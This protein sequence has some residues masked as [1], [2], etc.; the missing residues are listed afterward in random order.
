M[1][2][3]RRRKTAPATAAG[4]ASRYGAWQVTRHEGGAVGLSLV[5]GA[6]RGAA[7]RQMGALVFAIAN[8]AAPVPGGRR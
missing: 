6:E 5:P 2:I 3:F 1:R 8:Q 7:A 4:P